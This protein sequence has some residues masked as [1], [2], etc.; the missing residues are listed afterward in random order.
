MSLFHYRKEFSRTFSV[1][2]CWLFFTLHYKPAAATSAAATA[3][4]PSSNS[5]SNNS[6]KSWLKGKLLA[7]VKVK[8]AKLF[9]TRQVPRSW[10]HI[11]CVAVA[12]AAVLMLLLLLLCCCCCCV[13]AAAMQMWPLRRRS[14]S[15]DR[16]A[17]FVS[18]IMSVRSE[19]VRMRR[20]REING[21]TFVHLHVEIST[22]AAQQLHSVRN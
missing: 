15:H 22:L 12:V 18:L 3:T 1:K 9:K 16:S 14:S 8:A 13:A 20:L 21:E 5:R 4:S 2:K 7:K 6:N 11:V 17:L 10:I 19:R